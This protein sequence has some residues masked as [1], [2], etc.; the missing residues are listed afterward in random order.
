M[1]LKMELQIEHLYKS[2]RTKHNEY[3]FLVIFIISH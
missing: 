2:Y 1:D 3:L